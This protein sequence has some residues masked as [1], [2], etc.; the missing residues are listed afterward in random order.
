MQL[1][2]GGLLLI[3]RKTFPIFNSRLLRFLSDIQM[4]KLL[5]LRSRLHLSKRILNISI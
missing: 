3:D 1:N 4:S 2:T 5:S